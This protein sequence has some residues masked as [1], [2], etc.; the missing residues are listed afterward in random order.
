MTSSTPAEQWHI[1][2]C[3]VAAA[4][5]DAADLAA[6]IAEQSA[7]R[8][9]CLFAIAHRML[10]TGETVW[11]DVTR[12]LFAVAARSTDSWWQAAYAAAAAVR[13]HEPDL[14]CSPAAVV[15]EITD[16]AAVGRFG[17][18]LFAQGGDIMTLRQ[19]VRHNPHF[20]HDMW[21]IAAGLIG[22]GH[23]SSDAVSC[24]RRLYAAAA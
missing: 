12:E 11:Q 23:S 15:A 7:E 6:D 16:L 5:A 1:D 20:T 3:H 24:V 4:G 10:P 13:C 9:A 21:D 8:G 22:D 19:H 2:L 17:L 18:A 14:F